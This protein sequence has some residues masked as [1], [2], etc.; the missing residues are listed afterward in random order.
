MN[1][2]S[3]SV[4]GDDDDDELWYSE[5]IHPINYEGNLR[6]F[7]L[8]RIERDIRRIMN[9][10]REAGKSFGFHHYS[11]HRFPRLY[12]ET[13]SA[14]APFIR[15]T[16]MKQLGIV[17]QFKFNRLIQVDVQDESKVDYNALELSRQQYLEQYCQQL[18]KAFVCVR[19]YEVYFEPYQVQRTRTEWYREFQ[20]PA[21]VLT[22]AQ[23][24]ELN[25]LRAQWRGYQESSVS[26]KQFA[27]RKQVNCQFEMIKSCI[28]QR[29]LLTEQSFITARQGQMEVDLRFEDIRFERHSFKPHNQWTL[30]ELYQQ[31]SSL[32]SQFWC[33]TPP[34]NHQNFGSIEKLIYSIPTTTAQCQTMI[35]TWIPIPA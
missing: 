33:Q 1:A 35:N 28:L 8:L 27:V 15:K 23:E 19:G 12:I 20:L 31:M 14:D 10:L 13:T 30:R 29:L 2:T 24:L 16:L 32:C 11:P 26:M 22:N 6:P 3:S 17:N 34:T 4:I 18:P 7:Q 5:Y 25:H 21:P 9:Q